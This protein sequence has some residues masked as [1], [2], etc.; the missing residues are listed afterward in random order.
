MTTPRGGTRRR[1]LEEAEASMGPPHMS[2]AGSVPPHTPNAVA[3]RPYATAH[4]A[5][6]AIA[7]LTSPHAAS[8]PLSLN[9]AL[10]LG[11]ASCHPPPSNP[12]FRPR[13]SALRLS[14]SKASRTA[15]PV[16]SRPEAAA[17][18]RLEE[19]TSEAS[20]TAARR[21]RSSE[22]AGSLQ[23]SRQR[24][25][26]RRGKEV[27]KRP[28]RESTASRNSTTG[29]RGERFCAVPFAPSGFSPPSSSSCLGAPPAPPL[30]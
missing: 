10:N 25:D 5:H 4:P 29:G 2:A 26:D 23:A 8:T 16:R 24:R 3:A 13:A 7:S 1:G 12:T 9:L 27:T 18:R 20:T 21:D 28:V 19:D 15:R 14:P 30:S 22:E 17:E 6:V 11:S